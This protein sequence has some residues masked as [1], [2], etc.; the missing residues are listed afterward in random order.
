LPDLKYVIL[1]ILLP[2]LKYAKL[3]ISLPDLK[4]PPPF[5]EMMDYRRYINKVFMEDNLI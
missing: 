1:G 5:A 3:G 4:F 2:D